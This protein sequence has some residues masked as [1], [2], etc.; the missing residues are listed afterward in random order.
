[1]LTEEQLDALVDEVGKRYDKLQDQLMAE[2]VRK[3]RQ[4]LD[5]GASIQWDV[6][7][8]L[9]LGGA[10]EDDVAAKIQEATGLAHKDVEKLLESAGLDSIRNDNA[11]LPEGHRL[12]EKL[13]AV[14]LRV[15]RAGIKKV[16]G[17]IGNMANVT[18]D[19]TLDLYGE[20]LSKGYDML[21][22]GAYSIEQATEKVGID[23]VRAGVKGIEYPSGRKDRIE[24]AV[25]RALRTGTNQTMLELAEENATMAETDLV[26]VSAHAGARPE[27]AI[28]Q[29]KVYSLSGKT[30]GY[31]KLS[32][33]TG[34]GT[35][36]GLGGVN[37]RHS[38]H[39]FY[40]GFSKKEHTATELRD[41]KNEAVTV[42]GREMP[43]YQA[44]QL[45]RELE[46]RYRE[47][48]RLQLI[49]GSDTA[50]IQTALKTKM[51]SLSKQTGIQ[52][53]ESRLKVYV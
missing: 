18:L 14:Q 10:W 42:D 13:S 3:V 53:N 29:G 2:I 40:P 35:V 28:W 47:Q 50:A 11:F 49:A 26:E 1:M 32:D 44:T 38:F 43:L 51:R 27:H 23:L 52:V 19:S 22:S 36:T 30:K 37:C 8:Y 20:L 16:N 4:G 34:Y 5:I 41:M 31:A 17:A 9:E 46:R 39:P 33:A 48:K 12:E 15:I 21:S 6:K 25:R 24:V 45:M 7:K